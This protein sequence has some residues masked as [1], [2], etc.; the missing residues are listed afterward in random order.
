[1]NL[2]NATYLLKVDNKVVGTIR[3]FHL[4][5]INEN[6]QTDRIIVEDHSLLCVPELIQTSESLFELDSSVKSNCSED[7]KYFLEN[8]DDYKARLLKMI[9]D[10]YKEI[11]KKQ[12]DIEDLISE[13]YKL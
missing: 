6:I 9:V 13:L 8:E 3:P 7:L 11:N 10:T 2:K 12:K 5:L 4:Y 1:M